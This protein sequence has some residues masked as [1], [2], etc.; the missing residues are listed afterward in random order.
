MATEQTKSRGLVLKRNALGRL[1][2]HD[3][4]T[5]EML[6]GQRNV[7]VTESPNDYTTITVTFLATPESDVGVRLQ[8]DDTDSD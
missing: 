8:V 7:Q 5:G 1:S 6:A 3:A 4:E 2:L